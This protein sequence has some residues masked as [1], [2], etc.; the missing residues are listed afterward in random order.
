MYYVITYIAVLLTTFILIPFV[1]VRWKGILSISLV[2]ISAIISGIIGVR[3]LLGIPVDI[4]LHGTYVTGDIPIR[5][6]ALSG[7]FMLV[8]NFTAVT[9]GIYGLQYMKM[10][11]DQ[12]TSISLHAIL[13][14]LA[15]VMLTTICIV[16]NVIVF[17]FAWETMALSLT[18][19]VIFEYYKPDTIKAGL[20]YIIQSHLC[21]VF[22][23]V[24]FIW[25][26]TRMHSFDFN[27]IHQ[28]SIENPVYLSTALLFC[29]ML[30]FA[31][32]AGFVPFHTWLPYA[33]PAAPSHISGFMSGVAIKIGIY[34]IL[35]MILLIDANYTTVGI[36]ILIIS[37]FSGLYGVMLAIFQHNLK[38][39]LAYHSVENIGIIGIGIGVGAI[40]IGSNNQ[41]IATLGFA[42]ALLHVLNHSLFK[43]LLFYSAGN[44]YQA[45]HTIN[46]EKLGGLIKQMPHTSALFLIAALAICGLPPFNGFI[47][48]FFIYSGL[49]NGLINGNLVL[50][51]SF[52]FAVLGLVLIGGLALLCFTKA[53]GTVF[54][55]NPRHHFQKTP[56]EGNIYKL[57]PMYVIG[58]ML[59]VIGL[60]PN[61]IFNILSGPITLFTNKLSL[62]SVGLTAVY[63]ITNT[64]QYISWCTLGVIALTAT[65][66][67][68]RNKVNSNKTILVAPTWG[69]GYVGDTSRMQYSAS[70][71]VRSYRK[72]AKPLLTLYKKKE[73]IAGVFPRHASI[74]ISVY[75]KLEKWFIDY[76]L[77]QIKYFLSLFKFIQNGNPQFY[78]L[79]GVFFV[80]MIL[81]APYLYNM[82]VIFVK[83]LNQL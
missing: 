77:K 83:F 60:F 25:V 8:I 46:I 1:K 59:L 30:G 3:A 23:S 81:G 37:T 34:G 35:R 53:F 39:L 16:Q 21:I 13:F 15:Q 58:G 28:F 65:L 41:L 82:L 66:F 80:V 27:A 45:T 7:W 11:K 57:I 12:T 43:S 2:I 31:F 73:E 6:D 36:I 62:P 20:N 48:E 63:K 72:M 76:P 32:K 74:E 79:Y 14:V 67:F 47:S 49:F 64:M 54:L 78:I 9:A 38:K 56:V 61:V 75:D 17:L 55:G 10:Y 5:I 70:S 18:L 40:G 71:F 24:G 19:L 26:A 52:V 22:L 29:F 33:H 50:I 69:C 4:I 42:G 51:I 44:V 68:I